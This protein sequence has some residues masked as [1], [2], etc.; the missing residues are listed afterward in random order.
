M[1]AGFGQGAQRHGNS[2]E[3]R[4]RQNCAIRALQRRHGFFQR[5]GRRCT[6]ATVADFGVRP[7]QEILVGTRQHRGC[8][9]DRRIDDT[10][11]VVGVVAAM[12]DDRIV[13]HEPTVIVVV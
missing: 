4:G 1:I 2:G 5:E 12:G 6:T 10:V 11:V 8:V 3:P 9:I 13:F 7:V